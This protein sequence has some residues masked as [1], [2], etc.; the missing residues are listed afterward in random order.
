MGGTSWHAAV[1]RDARSSLRKTD[2]RRPAG[3][4]GLYRTERFGGHPWVVSIPKKVIPTSVRR[5]RLKRLIREAMRETG[6]VPGP[7]ETWK[8]AV[9]A[10]PNHD[11]RMKDVAAALVAL[12]E[13]KNAKKS[14]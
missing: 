12:V 1:K 9:R 4:I 14:G 3:W 5:S 2:P 10:N 6:F 8:F 11:I 7:T 13:Q